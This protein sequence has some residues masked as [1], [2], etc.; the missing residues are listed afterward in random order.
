MYDVVSVGSATVDVFVKSSKKQTGFAKHQDHYDVCYHIGGKILVDEIHFDTGGGG[1]NTAAAFARLGLKAAYVGKVGDDV[2][3]R[4]VLD[5]LRHEKVAFLGAVDRSRTTGYSV[6]LADLMSDRAILAYKG[7]N[8]ALS[9]SDVPA[10]AL[11]ARG[12]YFSSMLG[13]SWRTACALAAKARA[14]GIRYAFNPSTY[15]AQKGIAFLR[16][17]IR[18]ASLL[19]LNLE[20]ARDLLGKMSV[21]DLLW[22]LR[23]EM[24][25]QDCAVIIT[26]GARGAHA[27]DGLAYHFIRA[28]K[29]R[30]IETTGAGDAFAAGVFAGLL[31]GWPLKRS[32]ILGMCEAEGVLGSVGAKAGLLSKAQA[33]RAVRARFRITTGAL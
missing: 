30:V 33:L 1:T 32:L 22:R 21:R 16:P 19:V 23:R 3:G 9:S 4:T 28:R 15:L 29:V 14:K 20:E 24:H 8:D 27:Y 25:S 12:M 13:A 6:V 5:A 17:M 10:R 18:G 7:A 26:D 2:H 31:R 11:R